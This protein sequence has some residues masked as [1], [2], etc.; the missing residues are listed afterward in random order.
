MTASINGVV[1][2]DVEVVPLRV[3]QELKQ[4]YCPYHSNAIMLLRYDLVHLFILCFQHQLPKIF[5][6]FFLGLTDTEF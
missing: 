5:G 1:L 6:P 3:Y 4:T 2:S